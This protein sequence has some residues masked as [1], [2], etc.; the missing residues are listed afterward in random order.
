MGRRIE[1]DALLRADS[2]VLARVEESQP[3]LRRHRPHR[4]RQPAR[5]AA[6]H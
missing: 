4:H 3:A 1:V 2:D 6:R 5:L